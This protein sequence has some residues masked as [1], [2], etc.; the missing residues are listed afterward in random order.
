[1]PPPCPIMLAEDAEQRPVSRGGEQGASALP[2]TLGGARAVGGD[3]PDSGGKL[4]WLEM[5]TNPSSSFKARP[6]SLSLRVHA[7][8]CLS[9][10]SPVPPG[11]SYFPIWV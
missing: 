11:P 4:C 9:V 2:P 8:V 3:M 5:F 1:M 6:L 10:W 7:W